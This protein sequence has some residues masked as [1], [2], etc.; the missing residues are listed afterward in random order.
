MWAVPPPSPLLA[1][2]DKP[3]SCL[4]TARCCLPLPCPLGFSLMWLPKDVATIKV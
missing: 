1:G 4:P 2:G 3:Q